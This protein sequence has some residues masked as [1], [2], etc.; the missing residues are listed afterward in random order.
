MLD[1]S[2]GAKISLK[3]SLQLLGNSRQ[4]AIALFF[5]DRITLAGK[6]L[7]LGSVQDGDATAGVADHLELLS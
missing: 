4:Q 1:R 2:G 3:Q 6:S 5:D 7:K